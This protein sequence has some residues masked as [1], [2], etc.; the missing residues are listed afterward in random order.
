MQNFCSV[1]TL[2]NL[3][4]FSSLS[5]NMKRNLK[6]DPFVSSPPSSYSHHTSMFPSDCFC[7]NSVMLRIS[8]LMGIL[9]VH[10]LSRYSTH[11]MKCIIK[12]L[13]TAI[14]QILN[15]FSSVDILVTIISVRP[16]NPL[17]FHI[18]HVAYFLIVSCKILLFAFIYPFR[19]T[20]IN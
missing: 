9:R 15:Q 5:L 14:E 6:H 7:R 19:L 12:E 4:I 2:P 11:Q 18:F 17:M 16:N 1:H 10:R 20:Y 13:T 3:F 8:R